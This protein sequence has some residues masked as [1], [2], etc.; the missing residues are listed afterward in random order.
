MEFIAQYYGRQYQPNTR[1]TIRRQTLHQFIDAGLVAYNP[2]QPNRAV[3]S[4]HAC[5]QIISEVLELLQAYAT[6]NWD[7]L[8]AKWLQTHMSLAHQYAKERELSRIP[9]RIDE[10]RTVNLSPGVHSQ[11]IY[12]IIMG[13][14][15]RLGSRPMS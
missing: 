7:S 2:D 4:P 12:D 8:L 11:L 9:L 1:E 6:P 10:S 5:Y 15:P 3:N 13:F 14:G